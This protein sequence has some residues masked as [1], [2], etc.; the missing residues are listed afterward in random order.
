MAEVVDLVRA[1]VVV[2]KEGEVMVEA[3]VEAKVAA[4]S[5]VAKVEEG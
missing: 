5:V 3:M 2:A 1:M 4:E